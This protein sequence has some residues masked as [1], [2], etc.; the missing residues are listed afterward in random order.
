[1]KDSSS[2]IRLAIHVG[3]AT[4]DRRD[5]L[6]GVLEESHGRFD[7]CLRDDETDDVWGD[8]FRRLIRGCDVLWTLDPVRTLAVA[9]TPNRVAA[10]V[11]M[12]VT[13][14]AHQDIEVVESQCPGT[15]LSLF[16]VFVA[17]ADVKAHGRAWGTADVVA[18][19]A[20]TQG[21][22]DKVGIGAEAWTNRYESAPNTLA[23]TWLPVAGTLPIKMRKSMDATQRRGLAAQLRALKKRPSAMGARRVLDFGCGTGRFAPLLVEVGFEDYLGIDPSPSVIKE[24]AK[25]NPGTS[26]QSGGVTQLGA[27][28]E[29]SFDLILCSTVMIHLIEEDQ[30]TSLEEFS[31]LLKPG[32]LLVFLEDFVGKRQAEDDASLLSKALQF[33]QFMLSVHRC[34]QRSPSL[35]GIRT[36]H[37]EHDW[38]ARAAIVSLEV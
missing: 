17:D 36:L 32:G 1:M 31:R 12:D 14:A 16:D 24:A 3:R 27:F 28:S 30:R 8:G 18:A 21:P 22:P 23:R 20:H 34:L 4:R 11:V 37:Y 13:G 26:F 25:A 38:F 5:H 19:L 7:V 9:G 33:E 29:A 10:A 6:L 15:F 2:P 35:V